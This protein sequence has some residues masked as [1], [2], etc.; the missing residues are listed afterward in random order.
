M[1]GSYVDGVAEPACATGALRV[2]A[3][4]DSAIPFTATFNTSPYACT[5]TNP[6]AKT[7]GCFSQSGPG[8]LLS[9]YAPGVQILAAGQT[10][11]GTSQATPHVAG[12]I[13]DLATFV[14]QATAQDL[15]TA[16]TTSATQLSDSRPIS[17][18]KTPLLDLTQAAAQIHYLRVQSSSSTAADTP[19]S[20]TV[21]ALD[22]N[23]VAQ[24]S[25]SGSLTVTSSDPGATLPSS[26]ALAGGTATFSVTLNH[27]GNQTI[28]VSGPNGL[29]G[30]SGPITVFG[31]TTTTAPTTTTTAPPTP[32][33]INRISGSDRIATSVAASQ[34]SYP[35]T[36]SAGAVVLASA[37]SYPDGLAGTP[38]AA[39]LHAPIL[40]S[41][42]STLRT[43]V[44][45]EVSRAMPAGGAVYALGGTAALSTAVTDA[46]TQAGFHV[47]R[48][49]GPD[50]YGTATA[51]AD[52]IPSPTT[53]LLATGL[54]FPDALA[55]GVA[56][57]HAH[58]VVLFTQGTT[59]AS[60]TQTWL[61][62]HSSL[63]VVI[64]GGTAAGTAAGATTLAGTDR[65][66]TSVKV[67]EHFF[68]TLT[69]AAVASGQVFPDA[70]SGG[71]HIAALDGPILLTQPT[72][73]P[74][75]VRA[76]FV[77][78]R[79]TIT[80]V[81]LYGGTAAIADAVGTQVVAATS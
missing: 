39:S 35:T 5:Q 18:R 69:A 52:A 8:A 12:A 56:A 46:L 72:T 60:A 13:A 4:Y 75:S 32:A 19:L 58:G 71:A 81:Y 79:G 31:G 1:N 21:S 38:L 23:G 45:T 44:L 25:T 7:I 42:A 43:D 49:A 34:A 16:V 48:L 80:T 40:L 26:A 29:K 15:V 3:E 2:G 37:D 73:L 70:L 27:N 47:H 17:V 10:L 6:P 63:P 50:R 20:V 24:P 14:P 51:I 57:A 54:N 68:T 11:S 66:E 33:T 28:S 36:H 67:A 53:V 62:A 78:R 59:Q 61:A 55:A 9:V 76:W 22:G 30:I 41:S 74:T 77:A 64:V 65:Y